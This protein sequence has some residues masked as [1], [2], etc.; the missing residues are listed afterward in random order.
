[1]ASIAL[2]EYIAETLGGRDSLGAGQNG[3][4]EAKLV[5]ALPDRLSRLSPAC[6]R[7]SVYQRLCAFAQ[8]YEGASQ[9]L[10]AD[11]NIVYYTVMAIYLLGDEDGRGEERRRFIE[12]RL[13]DYLARCQENCP[14]HV[15]FY[16]KRAKAENRRMISA[17]RAVQ[18]SLSR[19]GS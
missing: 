16:G 1:M 18:T 14:G 5:L 4:P 12:R 9:C 2:L 13:G 3:D 7:H 17:Q 10:Q 11:K 8:A 15:E 6:L 19:L